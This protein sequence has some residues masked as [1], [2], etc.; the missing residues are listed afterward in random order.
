VIGVP[1]ALS[2]VAPCAQIA[3]RFQPRIKD[4]FC[5]YVFFQIETIDR[6][7]ILTFGTP[8]TKRPSWLVTMSSAHDRL[9]RIER[10]LVEQVMR[11]QHEPRPHHMRHQRL[12]ATPDILPILIARQMVCGAVVPDHDIAA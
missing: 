2:D 12:K 1:D 3:K 4:R 6:R 9:S 10:R 11:F 7:A 5:R 8:L